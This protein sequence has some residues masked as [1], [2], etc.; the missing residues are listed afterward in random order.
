M[1]L[2]AAASK[3]KKQPQIYPAGQKT[4]V[5]V[6]VAI[7]GASCHFEGSLVCCILFFIPLEMALS[8]AF[9]PAD[10]ARCAQSGG[11]SAGLA[12]SKWGRFVALHSV[13][14]DSSPHR[15]NLWRYG[16]FWACSVAL[17]PHSVAH[18]AKHSVQRYKW[19]RQGVV[20]PSRSVK[21]GLHTHPD[22]QNRPPAPLSGQNIATFV[23]D[24]VGKRTHTEPHGRG[25][26]GGHL[27]LI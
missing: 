7:N 19:P 1:W 26:A 22:T 10:S 8:H 25:R 13:C 12:Q 6:S 20:L 18:S 3:K 15:V 16:A 5:C 11:G 2:P 4:W 14:G 21:L 27:R 17:F 24:P 23:H 9:S